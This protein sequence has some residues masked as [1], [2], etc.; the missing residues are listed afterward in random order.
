MSNS[1]LQTNISSYMIKIYSPA[2]HRIVIIYELYGPC[3]SH[4]FLLN[5]NFACSVLVFGP[6]KQHKLFLQQMSKVYI[7]RYRIVTTKQAG[8]PRNCGLI[9][10][11][12]RD[13]LVLHS[14]QTMC[15]VHTTF[16]SIGTMGPF[17]REKAAAA[18]SRPLTTM[19]C[20]TAATH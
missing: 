15:G 13:F 11:K 19:Y 14:N 7:N 2:M 8:Q 5:T 17:P 18:T 20:L 9:V 12:A 3:E 1:C 16:C 6:H 4:Y 10:G